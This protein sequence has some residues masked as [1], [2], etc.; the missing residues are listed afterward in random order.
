MAFG[1]FG[2]FRLWPAVECVVLVVRGAEPVKKVLGYWQAIL[3]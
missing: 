1:I 2:S 3:G